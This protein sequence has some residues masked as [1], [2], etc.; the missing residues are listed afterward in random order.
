[1]D[2]LGVIARI[3]DFAWAMLGYWWML[4]AGII[5]AVEPMI[6][7]LA[8]EQWKSAIDKKWPKDKRR[9]HFRW[10]AVGALLL[11]SFFAFDDANMRN[12]EP[13]RQLN[14]AHIAIGQSQRHL[15]PDQ[16]ERLRTA[17]LPIAKEIPRIV[18]LAGDG[19]EARFAADFADA[20]RKA[21]IEPLGPYTGYISLLEKDRG[22][23]VGILDINHPSDLAVKFID[24]L[25]LAEMK[26]TRTMGNTIARQAG[27]DFNLFIGPP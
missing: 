1:M 14:A 25:T 3:Y 2:D 11:S 7:G 22:V 18:I 6:E 4:V 19:E 9:A 15:E 27:I 13:Q 23:L 8:P 21:G 5:F 16:K 10:A 26:P 12:R 20:F 24:A 17:L